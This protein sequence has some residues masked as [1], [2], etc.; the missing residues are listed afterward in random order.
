MNAHTWARLGL[1][2]AHGQM[3]ML[4]HM[5]TVKKESQNPAYTRMISTCRQGIAMETCSSIHTVN[6]ASAGTNLWP[7]AISHLP[8]AIGHGTNPHSASS[9]LATSDD[10]KLLLQTRRQV[11]F[12]AGTIWNVAWSVH[13][14]TA[15]VA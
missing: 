8:S 13:G 5:H 10:W 12:V 9:A 11:F 15:R 1:R 2:T 3:H 6:A 4:L 14:S 7:S